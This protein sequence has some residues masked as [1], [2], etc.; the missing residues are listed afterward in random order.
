MWFRRKKKIKEANYGKTVNDLK[1]QQ[2]QNISKLLEDSFLLRQAIKA[3]NGHEP[4]DIP[5]SSLRGFKLNKLTEVNPKVKTKLILKENKRLVFE[6]H[7][8]KGGHIAEHYHSDCLEDVTITEGIMLD[9]T[10]GEKYRSSESVEYNYNEKHFV[11]ALE[12]MMLTVVFLK[13]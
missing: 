7:F 9:A 1:K 10:S 6:T 3:F 4:K 8:L 2:K 5:F 12:D 11:V 13:K